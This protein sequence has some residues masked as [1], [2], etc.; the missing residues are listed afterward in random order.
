VRARHQVAARLLKSIVAAAAPLG[1]DGA[2]W[3]AR[4]GVT[5][6]LAA[7]GS[8]DAH[9]SLAQY[10]RLW[11]VALVESGRR[12][13]PLLAATALGTDSFGVIGF[14]CMTSPTVGAAFGHLARY[15]G[16][17]ST[18]GGWTLEDHKDR[19][20]LLF[21]MEGEPSPG[22]ACAVEFALAESVHFAR[23]MA[24]RPLAL[25]EARFPHDPPAESESYQRLFQA[26]LRWRAPRAALVLERAV[27]ETPLLRADPHLLA[28]FERQAD[29]LAAQHAP[30]E[31]SAQVRRLVIQTLPS[32]APPLQEVA[33]RL[34]VSER[35]LRRR[36]ADEGTSFQ[37]LLEETRS[38]LA[39][40]YL[41]DPRLTVSEIAFLCGFSEL[42][43]FQRAFRRWTG[44][45]PRAFRARG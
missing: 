17:L 20:S 29:A 45:T 33:R 22:L 23:L 38:E 21:E 8:L 39:Q 42:S 34:G 15:Y 2:R 44:L 25:V 1:L 24:E 30:R 14:S 41:R 26:P 36:L 3:A 13:L 19:L 27:F 4:A 28:Y 40:R 12:D 37:A 6:D 10:L 11:E 32:G 31:L 16:V 9:F 18:A 43:P 5:V 35:S 7:A